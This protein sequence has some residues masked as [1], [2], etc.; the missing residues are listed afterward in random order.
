MT[1]LLYGVT[2]AC[3]LIFLLACLVRALRYARAPVHLRW[4]LYPVPHEEPERVKH[5]GSYFETTDWWTKPSHFNLWGEIRFMVP[6]MIFLKGLWEFNRKMWLR[7][8]PFHFGLYLLI[9]SAAAVLVRA[10]IGLTAP[11]LEAGILVRGLHDFYT[12]TTLAGLALAFWGALGL[13]LHRLTDAEL[14]TYTTPGDIFNLAFFTI[15]LGLLAAAYFLGE[16]GSPGPAGLARG[17]L[18]L[19]TSLQIPAPL[20]AGLLSAALLMAYIPLTHMSHFIAKW[21]TYHSVRWDDAPG[22][23]NAQIRAKVAESLMYRPTWS[24]AH[25]GADGKK[26]WAEVATADPTK[27]TRQ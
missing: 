3:V 8:F 20:A 12:C 16:P 17:L 10:G 27:G 21:F 5:G 15:T 24:A 25:M 14:R 6:E 13:L 19:D 22:V 26:N 2:Y 18:T 4:E 11:Q 1:I 23:R 7:S 9:V